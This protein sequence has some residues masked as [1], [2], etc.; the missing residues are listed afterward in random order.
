[1]ANHVRRRSPCGE[2]GLK[3]IGNNI[4]SATMMSLPL[5][6]AWIEISAHNIQNKYAVSRS[7]C[8]ERGLKSGAT[9]SGYTSSGR[10]PC[11]ERGLK[12]SIV[13]SVCVISAS[14]SP[15]G[16]RGLKSPRGSRPLTHVRTRRSPCGERGLKS[17]PIFQPKKAAP[18]LPL[19]GAW[20]EIPDVKELYF[21]FGV[22][23]PAGSVD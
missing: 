11:G 14:R 16:E 23:P 7:P 3:Y 6:G 10:S 1:M 2:R 21:N 15:C 22:A 4:S 13:I 20:I 9:A 12:S 8:G 17:L 19:R 18:S 5:R